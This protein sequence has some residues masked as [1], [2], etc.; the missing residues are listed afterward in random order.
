V[1]EMKEADQFIVLCG[2]IVGNMQ[3]GFEVMYDWNHDLYDTRKAAIAAGLEERESDDFN[4]GVVRCGRL[5]S[6]DWMDEPH[7]EPP[8]TLRRIEDQIG[9]YEEGDDEPALSDPTRP[10]SK[11]DPESWPCRQTRLKKQDGVG[12]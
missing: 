10:D 9:L 6:L 5:V 11:N 2:S 7:H 12:G 4:I 3:D 1:S 8:E